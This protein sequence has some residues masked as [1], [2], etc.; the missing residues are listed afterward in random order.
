MH[1]LRVAH[2]VTNAGALED[3]NSFQM[4]AP[5]LKRADSPGNDDGTGIELGAGAGADAKTS[6]IPLLQLRHLLA[7]MKLGIEGL[8][9]LHEPVDQLLSAAHRQRRDVV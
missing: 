9:L 2:T 3:I 6:V 4:H 7:E 8:D 1:F 5:R